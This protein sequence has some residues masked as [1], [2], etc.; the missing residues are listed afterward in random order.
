MPLDLRSGYLERLSAAPPGPHAAGE[1]G[2]VPRG[3]APAVEACGLRFAYGGRTVLDRLDLSVRPGEVV[4]LLGPN[5]S[6]KSTLLRLL[7]GLAVPQAGRVRWW[8]VAASAAPPALRR[9][10]GVLSHE[11]FLFDELTAAENLAYYAAL[12]GLDA[13][14][15]RAREAL[16]LEGLLL[17][18]DRPVASLS[19]GLAQ[20]VAICRAW[21]GDPALILADE[22][23]TG[24]DPPATARFRARIAAQR[25]RGGAAVFTGHD[26]A[27]ALAL[28]DRYVLLGG[29][30]VADEGAASPWRGRG[31]AFAARYVAATSAA[32]RLGVRRGSSAGG[33]A[34]AP[35]V[36]AQ[37][38]PGAGSGASAARGRGGAWTAFRAVLGREARLWSRGRGRFGAMLAFGLLVAVVFGFALD[39][40]SVD[41]RPVFAGVVWTGT[42]FAALPALERSF[43]AEWRH[44]A[45]DG[46]RAAGADAAVLFYAKCVGAL[47]ALGAG[48]ALFCPAFGAMLQVRPGGAAGG[49]AAAFGLGALGLAPAGS[50]S[51][52]V[53]ARA[54]GGGAGPAVLPLVTLPVLAP[55]VLGAVRGAQAFLTGAGWPAAAPWLWLLGAYALLFWSLPYALFP[56]VAEA[57]A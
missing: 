31:D 23:E 9:R 27:A 14:A 42:M 56:V 10:L 7:A 35:A 4:A 50:L 17:H 32:R 33:P 15:E 28:A 38:A 57:G 19:R 30:N 12:L 36:A 55:G 29:A 48:L 16:R 34:E 51:A 53:V 18:A 46:Y 39:P 5:G 11:S 13:P 45:A 8:G 26:L 40:T 49:L 21:L 24:L 22:A 2:A 1:P 3:A 47:L 20:R 41:L 6:G 54:F 37:A 43:A 25:A 44:G 52:A